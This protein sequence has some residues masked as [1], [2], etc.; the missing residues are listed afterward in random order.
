MIP[1]KLQLVLFSILV[2]LIVSSPMTYKLTTMVTSNVGFVT[3]QGESP[4]KLG[5][6]LHALVFGLLMYFYLLTFKV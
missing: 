3:I 6:F 1:V 4:T 5:I 2:F